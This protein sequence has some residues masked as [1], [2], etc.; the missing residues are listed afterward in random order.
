MSKVRPVEARFLENR[1][2]SAGHL[3]AYSGLRNV[4]RMCEGYIYILFVPARILKVSN[5]PL[6]IGSEGVFRRRGDQT[7]S[8]VLASAL[9]KLVLAK[10]ILPSPLSR[11][12]FQLALTLSS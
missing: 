2:C 1:R 9:S 8:L 3:R 10:H 11:T 7:G 4:F 12:P 6:I 5:E